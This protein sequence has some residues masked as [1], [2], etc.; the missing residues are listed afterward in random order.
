MFSLAA[1]DRVLK[2]IMLNA[3]NNINVYIVE[4]IF[5]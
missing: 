4:K 2:W 1:S 5:V 3:F